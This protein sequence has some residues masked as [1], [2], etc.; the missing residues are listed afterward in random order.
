MPKGYLVGELEVT[1]PAGYQ[2]YGRN[3]PAVIAKFGGR[4]HARGGEAR[5]L[6]G[7]GGPAKRVVVVEFDSPER[8]MEFYNSP[9]YQAILP[10]RLNNSVGRVL[11]VAGY[12]PA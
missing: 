9:E 2:E 8:L 1:N 6:E 10:H 7:P 5:L 11:C 3:V 12:E 4:Y